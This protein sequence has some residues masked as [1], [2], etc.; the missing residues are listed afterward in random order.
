[1]PAGVC[2]SPE[3][4]REICVR[5]VVANGSVTDIENSGEERWICRVCILSRPDI[6]SF[7]VIPIREN[8]CGRVARLD[9]CTSQHW[10]IRTFH[11][12]QPGLERRDCEREGSDQ[13]HDRFRWK[14]RRCR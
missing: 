11:R 1:M 7:R 14:E 8:P 3:P 13:G 4:E 5:A 9:I 6:V 12:L 10:Y 2:Q